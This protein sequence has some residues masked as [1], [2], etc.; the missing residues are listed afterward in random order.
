MSYIIAKFFIILLFLL[1]IM[2]IITTDVIITTIY[3]DS[4]LKGSERAPNRKLP[5]LLLLLLGMGKSNRS[6]Q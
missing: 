1:S 2:I 3:Y 4:I 5:I 6:M